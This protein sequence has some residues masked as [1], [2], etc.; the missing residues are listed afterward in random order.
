MEKIHP[1]F[2]T[3]TAGKMLVV[4]PANEFN[5]LMDEL[6]EQDDIRLFLEAKKED[7]GDRV[8]FSDYLRNR[9]ANHG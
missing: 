6:E 1:Q 5:S 2:I 4:L 3:D 9:N 8:L 7:N